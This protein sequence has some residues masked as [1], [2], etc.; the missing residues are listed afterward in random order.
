MKL[1][2]FATIAGLVALVASEPLPPFIPPSNT[3]PGPSGTLSYPTGGQNY[4]NIGH[5]GALFPAR[6]FCR[7]LADASVKQA[8]SASST[9]R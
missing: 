1:F 7:G 9:P 5:K 8:S 6:D 3:G 2:L 4:N